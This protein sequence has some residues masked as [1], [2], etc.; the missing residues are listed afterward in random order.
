MA[1][2]VFEFEFSL[3]ENPTKLGDQSP[4]LKQLAQQA[5]TDRAHL[6]RGVGPGIFRAI[7]KSQKGFI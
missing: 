1:G 2:G 7:K 3:R 5:R 6:L 4:R